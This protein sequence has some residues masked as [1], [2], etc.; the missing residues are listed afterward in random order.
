MLLSITERLLY[1]LPSNLFMMS[2]TEYSSNFRPLI[3]SNTTIM[4]Y[5]ASL[6]LDLTFV[7]FTPS[8]VIALNLDS[9]ILDLGFSVP[10]KLFVEEKEIL[11]VWD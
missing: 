3:R 7:Y 4:F 8:D 2:F 1:F 5:T 11:L 9:V 6:C 10:K